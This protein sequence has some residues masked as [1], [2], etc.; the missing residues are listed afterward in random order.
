MDS[1]EQQEKDN[2]QELSALLSRYAEQ[3]NHDTLE[4][5]AQAKKEAREQAELEAKGILEK[6][7]QEAT[8]LIEKTRAEALAAA[9][10]ETEA[11]KRQAQEQIEAWLKE[12]KQALTAQL[13]GMSGMLQKELLAQSE[14]LKRRA[15]SLQAEFEK[16]MSQV[17]NREIIIEG[18]DT[19]EKQPARP[20]QT[21]VKT[22]TEAAL[23]RWVELKI[24]PPFVY[25]IL[26]IL[27][28]HVDRI[29]EVSTSQITTLGSSTSL[30]VYLTKPID[31]CQQLSPL[32]EVRKVEEVSEKGDKK[33][34]LTLAE[35]PPLESLKDEK[36]ESSESIIKPKIQEITLNWQ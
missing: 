19:P 15:S 36:T 24:N 3:I 22:A 7:G 11:M 17:L 34:R 6:A 14:E 13:R 23:E 5:A 1:K 9:A 4:W 27:K 2:S 26:Q 21:A 16:Q 20:E 35:K 32:P 10:K 31:L 29:P 33:I 28:G 30:H 12:Q 8:L 18:A 25:G